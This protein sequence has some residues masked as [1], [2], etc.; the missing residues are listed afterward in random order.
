MDIAGLN[1][2]EILA[3]LYNGSRQQCMGY[4]DKRG[5]DGMTVEQAQEEIDNWPRMYFD[6][7]HGRV[8]KVGL[9]GNDLRTEAY[10]RDNGPGAAE[11]IIAD[12]RANV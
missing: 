5:A 1:K 10:N 8:L 4:L 11:R 3:A 7:L 6:Y 12:L 2:A 9:A